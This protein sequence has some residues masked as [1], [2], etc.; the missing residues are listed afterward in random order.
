MANVRIVTVKLPVSIIEALDE[1]VRTGKYAN[2]SDAIRAAVRDLIEKELWFSR[3]T[4]GI[5]RLPS[6]VGR[7]EV[8]V[9]A[10]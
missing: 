1:L 8:G 4:T 2:R 9:E 10:A 3:R 7:E 5:I 6:E